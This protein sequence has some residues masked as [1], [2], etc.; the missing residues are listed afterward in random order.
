MVAMTPKLEAALGVHA[1]RAMRSIEDIVRVHGDDPLQAL[2]RLHAVRFLLD[3]VVK[4]AEAMALPRLAAEKVRRG[5][6][7][8]KYDIKVGDV[9]FEVGFERNAFLYGE[10]YP[11]YRK[12]MAE[13]RKARKGI[14]QATLLGADTG[15]PKVE[16]REDRRKIFVHLTGNKKHH[17]EDEEL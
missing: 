1:D 17:V 10:G 6:K 16:V 14:R 8:A 5:I 4:E 12:L 3:E 15:Y 9:I 13:L 11:P 7:H 2:W